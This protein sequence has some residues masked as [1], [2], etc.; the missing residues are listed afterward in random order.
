MRVRIPSRPLWGE[1]NEQATRSM[2]QHIHRLIG[3]LHAALEIAED[4]KARARVGVED[5]GWE[6]DRLGEKLN[7]VADNLVL[8]EEVRREL[9]KKRSLSA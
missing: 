7:R 3:D 1:M 9:E 8:A 2:T 4:I 5:L 6:L